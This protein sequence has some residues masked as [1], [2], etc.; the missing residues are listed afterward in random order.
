MTQVS[1]DQL[2]AADKAGFVGALGDIFE[3]APWVAE[4]ARKAAISTLAALDAMV[5]AVRTPPAQTAGIDQATPR[6]CREG[7]ARRHA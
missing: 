1:L 6:P 4:A 7:G 2:N 3:Q 5:S